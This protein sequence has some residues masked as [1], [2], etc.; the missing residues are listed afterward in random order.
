MRVSRTLFVVAAACSVVVFGAG[1][2]GSNDVAAD[3]GQP[4]SAGSAGDGIDPDQLVLRAPSEEELG[5]GDEPDAGPPSPPTIAGDAPPPAMKP[6]TTSTTPPPAPDQTPEP[7]EPAQTTTISPDGAGTTDPTPVTEDVLIA[8]EDQSHSMLNQLRE[9]LEVS[10]LTR[11][12]T[13]DAFARDWSRQMAETGEFGHSTG[14]YGENIVFT[15]NTN[16]T[17]DEVAAQFHQL[18][19]DSPDHY[20]NMKNPRYAK[21][22]I[23]LYLTERGW[24]GT[25]VFAF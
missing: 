12:P 9:E 24:Y 2:S 4:N 11:D 19:I 21:T 20:G 5:A 18:W 17:A 7:V 8:V 16:L 1:C 13:M 22:G 25:H 10:A 6:E 3:E 23:G 14:P 15:S